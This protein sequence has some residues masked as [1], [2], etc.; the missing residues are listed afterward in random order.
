MQAAVA[1]AYAIRSLRVGDLAWLTLH[2]LP[3]A[4][5][6]TAQVGFASEAGAATYRSLGF[7]DS[8]TDTASRRGF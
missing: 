4:G 8:A 2:A 7:E 3:A 1:R 6:T 5:A